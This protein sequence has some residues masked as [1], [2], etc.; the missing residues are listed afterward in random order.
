MVHEVVGRSAEEVPLAGG[1]CRHAPVVDI[2]Q[3]GDCGR[4]DQE[5]GTYGGW[6]V[7]FPLGEGEPA[8]P[9]GRTGLLAPQAGAYRLCLAGEE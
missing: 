1:P 4:G 7:A 5:R 3:A 6:W 9:A 2:I 8:Y